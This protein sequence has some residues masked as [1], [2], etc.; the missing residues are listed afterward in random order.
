MMG[1]AGRE[2]GAAGAWRCSSKGV[3]APPRRPPFPPPPPRELGDE[4]R[5]SGRARRGPRDN[6]GASS[7]PAVTQ[8][9]APSV[10]PRESMP[11]GHTGGRRGGGGDCVTGGRR[12]GGGAGDGTGCTA[13]VAQR[14]ALPS[15]RGSRWGR[16]S[17]GQTCGGGPVREAA[18]RHQ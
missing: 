18:R 5:L 11:L 13:P 12:G 3:R 8:G 14:R 10:R 9:H 16:V 1:S 7:G 15:S 6:A 4:G 2:R 17:R